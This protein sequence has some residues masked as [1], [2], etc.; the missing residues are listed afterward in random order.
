MRLPALVLVAALL[1]SVT[2]APG[3]QAAERPIATISDG[4]ITIDVL[5]APIADRPGK[6]RM[7]WD[8]GSVQRKVIQPDTDQIESGANIGIKLVVTWISQLINLRAATTRPRRSG[9]RRRGV[10]E[11]RE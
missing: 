11:P 5:R 10:P 6:I 8:L 7:S 3:A 9:N 2:V 4:P 1:G